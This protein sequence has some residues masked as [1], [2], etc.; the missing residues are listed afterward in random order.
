MIDLDLF[1]QFLKTLCQTNF[2]QNWQNGLHSA[3]WRSVTGSNMA[4]PIQ[5]IFSGNVLATSCVWDQDWSSNPRDC[6]GNNCNFLDE[7][8]KISIFHQISRELLDRSSPDFQHK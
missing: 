8:A 3:G 2:G 7:T 5:K 4:V 1:F 6:E